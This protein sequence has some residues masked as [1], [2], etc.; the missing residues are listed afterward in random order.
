LLVLWTL[1]G[2]L[3]TLAQ[4]SPGPLS[5]AH[6]D[7]DS[8]TR[9][10]ECHARGAASIEQRCLDCHREIAYMVDRDRGLHGRED[11]VDCARCHPEHGGR[12]FDLIAWDGEDANGFDHDRTAWPLEGKHAA[13]KCR[14]CHEARHQ[15]SDV[16]NLLKREDPGRSWL[17]LE[18]ECVSC[19]VD[20][21]QGTVGRDCMGCHGMTSWEPASR[22]DH[23]R[24]DF[25]L[26]GRHVEVRCEKCHLVPGRILLVTPEGLA[27][28]RYRPV[29]HAEC[30]DCHQDPHLGRLGPKC[31]ACHVTTRFTAV[32]RG[33]FD[34]AKTSY[35]LFGKHARLDCKACHDPKLGWGKRPAFQTCN[36]CHKEVHAGTA[37]LLG[38]QVDC[39]SCHN[40]RGFKPSTYTAADHDA[41]SYP[42]RGKHLQTACDKCH[43]K[44]AARAPLAAVG[45]AGVLIRPAHGRCLDCHEDSHGGQLAE[46]P[47]GGACEPCHTVEGW[48]PST[49]ADEDHARLRLPLTGRHASAECAACHAQ[50]RAGLPPLD[51]ALA[52]GRAKIALTTLDSDCA[53]CHFDPHDGRFGSAGERSRPAGCV[54]CHL[55]TSFRP[56]TVDE[57]THGEFEFPLEGGHLAVPCVGCHE[58]LAA[59]PPA[60]KLLEVRGAAR[61]LRFGAEHRRCDAC[62]ENPHGTQF[63]REDGPAECD[64]CHG[65]EGFRTA[66]RFDHE[67]Q[68]A[69]SLRGAHERVKCSACHPAAPAAEGRGPL[70]V[71]RPIAH[72]CVDCHGTIPTR[73]AGARSPGMARR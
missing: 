25:P 5:A 20:P 46:R 9:C 65:V 59:T 67:R 49:Y 32:E 10:L 56:A 31:S 1:C 6:A 45:T 58:E 70:V 11:L 69:F 73:S 50:N 8:P 48:K 34:H 33:A 2:G 72:E 17:G 29:P 52:P 66:S 60:I 30:S 41:S 4:V 3:A 14:D 39:R 55:D 28:P 63:V 22:F 35:P 47:G 36:S 23:A 12:E 61:L 37:T 16:V 42:L 64:S 40:E 21:H 44:D 62:H 54:A 71:Y 18:R 68:A 43:V 57:R 38:R 53:G 13:V 7:L 19:H 27:A 15:R 51:D 24:S 26:D